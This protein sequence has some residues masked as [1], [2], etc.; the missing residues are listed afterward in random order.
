LKVAWWLKDYK[1]Q[2]THP[3]HRLTPTLE[4][5]LRK[6]IIRQL[7]ER[8]DSIHHVDAIMA[9]SKVGTCI[10][11]GAQAEM[12]VED[13]LPRCLFPR[14]LP[15]NLVKVGACLTCNNGKSGDDAYLRDFLVADMAAGKSA[16]AQQI[17]TNTF[18][19]SVQTNRSEIAR[20]ALKRAYRKPLHTP[21]GIYLGSPIAVPIDAKHL[22]RIFERMVRGL[23]FHVWK[24]HLPRDYM[25]EVA[26][27]DGFHTAAVWSEMR[28]TGANIAAIRPDVFVCQYAFDIRYHAVSRWL[29]LFYNTILIEVFTLP[30]NGIEALI[31]EDEPDPASGLI[32]PDSDTSTGACE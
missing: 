20:L 16:V 21:G 11:C 8:R 25:F 28:Q 32:L 7:S 3:I 23:W 30:P 24:D 15:P 17:R 18:K 2:S 14:P 1:W 27:I 10:Y 4:S 5:C 13:V 9:K 12:T 22:E 19:R 29:L 26:R 6:G 31:T